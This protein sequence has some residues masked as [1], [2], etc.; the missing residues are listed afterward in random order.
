MS[1][2]VYD[3][4][5]LGREVEKMQLSY[6]IRY[7]DP[8]IISRI[9]NNHTEDKLALCTISISLTSIITLVDLSISK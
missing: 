6:T 8:L 7:I 4:S 5:R 3:N 2:P 9:Y 1:L